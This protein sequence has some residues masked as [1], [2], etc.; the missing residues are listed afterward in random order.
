VA[1]TLLA[2]SCW[3]CPVIATTPDDVTE[4]GRHQRVVL[5]L[6]GH[7]DA[8]RR[9]GCVHPWRAPA[10]ERRLGESQEVRRSPASARTSQRAQ[11]GASPSR[12]DAG[13]PRRR[14]TCGFSTCSAWR[15]H[16]TARG[17]R[18]TWTAPDAVRAV[19]PL[20][21]NSSSCRWP[22][23]NIASYR[24]SFDA[25]YTYNDGCRRPTA[26]PRSR[27]ATPSLR[28]RSPG[29]RSRVALLRFRTARAQRSNR[30]ARRHAQDCSQPVGKMAA[31]CE[32]IRPPKR[33]SCSWQPATPQYA[34]PAIAE[35]G[36]SAE[37]LSPPGVASRASL[38][39]GNCRSSSRTAG[40][41]DACIG[42][43]GYSPAR[44]ILP[45]A[46][47]GRLPTPA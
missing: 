6:T 32:D 1:A 17:R 18:Q 2:A 39:A 47:A 28:P 35:E 41:H 15:T 25:K 11:S 46:R 13:C 3:A 16:R 23:A 9:V 30:S 26:T 42:E 21:H 24:S 31:A 38:P 29:A 27:N 33:Q 40:Q 7:R 20:R 45:D 19:P 4:R 12:R 43:S 22:S 34:A 5:K 10:G 36:A 37:H 44:V 8:G 14:R